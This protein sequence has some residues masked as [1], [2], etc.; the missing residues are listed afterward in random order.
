VRHWWRAVHSDHIC[1]VARSK[2]YQRFNHIV[3]PVGAQFGHTLQEALVQFY[4]ILVLKLRNC[5]RSTS[6]ATNES[7]T[8]FMEHPLLLVITLF[9]SN[10]RITNKSFRQWCPLPTATPSS[11][12]PC[13]MILMPMVAL[14]KMMG[15]ESLVGNK[16]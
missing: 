12:K 10:C 9:A 15:K 8:F 16:F 5:F 14:C 7:V 11:A 2:Q 1:R 13:M 3:L 4:A 6:F